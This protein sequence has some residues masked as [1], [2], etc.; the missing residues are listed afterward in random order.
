MR[1]EAI[2]DNALESVMKQVVALVSPHIGLEKL[3]DSLN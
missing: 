3:Q 2:D 1:V